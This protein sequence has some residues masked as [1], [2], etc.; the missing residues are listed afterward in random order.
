[1]AEEKKEEAKPSGESKPQVQNGK[2]KNETQEHKP[3]E[4]AEMKE[5]L[6]RLAAEFD[7]YKKRMA[8][9][10]DEAKNTGKAELVRKILPTL[11][12]FEIAINA[13]GNEKSDAR[14][15]IELMYSNLYDSLKREG[16]KTV[17]SEGRYDPY[18]HEIVLVREGEGDEGMILET[19]R[20]GYTFN[21]ILIRPASVIVS[22]GKQK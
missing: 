22:K 12:E 19:I 2:G 8:K 18:K 7:N 21:S 6:L 17:D 4:N 1:M 5:R 14:K 16:L 9:D 20:K 10:V 11:D 3:D 13:M 15:G